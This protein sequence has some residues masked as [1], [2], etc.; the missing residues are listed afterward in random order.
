[1][2]IN[3][4]LRCKETSFEP[5]EYEVDNIIEAPHNEFEYFKSHLLGEHDFIADYAE[6]MKEK[7]TVGYHC[8]VL[9]DKDGND[10]II[11]DTQGTAY[12]RY[13]A[14]FP[15][16]R[17][18]VKSPFLELPKM[19]CE[20]AKAITEEVD[21]IVKKAI[22][23]CE[24]GCYSF[25]LSEINEEPGHPTFDLDL[26]K[27]MLFGRD[28]F[29]FVDEAGGEIMLYPKEE[30]LNSTNKYD[31]ERYFD[32]ACSDEVEIMCA[33][34]VLWIYSGDEG[35]KADLTDCKYVNIDFDG[36]NLIGAELGNVVMQNCNFRNAELVSAK[37]KYAKF[38]KCDFTGLAAE[39]AEFINC[40]FEECKFQNS[41]FTHANMKGS[42]FS[43]CEF[44]RSSFDSCLVKNISISNEDS[45]FP[46][47]LTSMEG[48]TDNEEEWNASNEGVIEQ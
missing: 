24:N 5:H 16:A 10:G 18:A 22:T 8:I 30:Y 28:E 12:A 32:E 11:I 2:R 44:I 19:V 34:H 43:D 7:E 35:E 29:A 25:Y 20:Y 6:Y 23:N 46:H 31:D 38:I 4:T 3:A 13:S 1:M 36:K 14:Y 9:L 15:N 33:K 40:S 41:F 42:R 21:D 17:Q 26:I 48:A 39:E 45:T 37:A 27:E 47:S